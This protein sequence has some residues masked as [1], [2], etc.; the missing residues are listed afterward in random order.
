[1]PTVFRLVLFMQHILILNPSLNFLDPEWCSLNLGVFICVACCGIHRHLGTHISRVK[2][3]KLDEWTPA[4]DSEME[5]NANKKLN[6]YYLQ[7]KPLPFKNIESSDPVY[8]REEIIIEKYVRKSF[9]TD[10]KW[11]PYKV[12]TVLK[13]GKYN[14]KWNERFFRLTNCSLVY[15]TSQNV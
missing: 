14:G 3:V 8:L 10:K 13:R 15:Y 7:H 5:N 9:V 12:G 11:A 6:E 4:M 1:M 2:S